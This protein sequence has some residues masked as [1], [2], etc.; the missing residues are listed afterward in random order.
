[1]AG[2]LEERKD[3]LPELTSSPDED[4]VWAVVDEIFAG[5]IGDP[6]TPEKKQKLLEEGKKRYE[7]DIPSGYEDQKKG[8]EEQF[9]D[10]L[11]WFQILDK[12]EEAGK[13]LVFVSDDRKDDWWWRPHGKTLGPRFELVDE[14]YHRAGMRFYMYSTQR[15]LEEARWFLQQEVSDEVIDEVQELASLEDEAEDAIDWQKLGQALA[16]IHGY[17]NVQ[18]IGE[19]SPLQEA[20]EAHENFQSIGERSPLQEAQ[21]VQEYVENL[22]RLLNAPTVR[23]F[24]GLS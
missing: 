6:Y 17:E 8:G 24:F 13:P 20:Q 23:K 7:A 19:R 10:A 18:N 21:E 22:R 3:E 14:M 5:R 15:F 4:E 2:H 11:L 12:A 16:Q 1:L 9:G